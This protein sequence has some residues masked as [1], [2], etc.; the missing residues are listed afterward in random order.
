MRVQTSI[1]VESM[2]LRDGGAGLVQDQRGLQ[3]LR[4]QSSSWLHPRR[5]PVMNRQ[6]DRLSL[7]AGDGDHQHPGS[8]SLHLLQPPKL[9]C[10][11]YQTSP[12]AGYPSSTVIRDRAFLDLVA[13][14]IRCCRSLLL[15]SWPVRGHRPRK[16]QALYY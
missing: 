6:E 10:K 16:K 11:S 8:A 1:D 4:I 14:H 9:R 13:L 2:G 12:T 3:W 5:L 15:W 7:G